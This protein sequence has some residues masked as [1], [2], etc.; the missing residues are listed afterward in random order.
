MHYGFDKTFLAID[1][2]DV[3]GFYNGFIPNL[4]NDDFVG[5]LG[6]VRPEREEYARQAAVG[7]PNF[8]GIEEDDEVI[9]PLFDL[10]SL[11]DDGSD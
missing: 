5:F 3:D 4:I 1:D 6:G 8:F 7:W 2:K 11:Y 9:V 10:D